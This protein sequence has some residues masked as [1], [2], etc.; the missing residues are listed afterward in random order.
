MNVVPKISFAKDLT[1]PSGNISLGAT[2]QL[3]GS[4]RLKANES[5]ELQKIALDFT[6]GNGYRGGAQDKIGYFECGTGVGK[7]LKNGCDM[8][9]SIKVVT[10]SGKVLLT[11]KANN[12]SLWNDAPVTLPLSSYYKIT[13]GSGVTL[14][15]IGFFP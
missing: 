1:S 2:D 13:S 3:L 9:G 5:V 7:N 11:V 15:I 12:P 10:D 14:K 8:S 6:G 4:F